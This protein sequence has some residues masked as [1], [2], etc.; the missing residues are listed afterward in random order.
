M[1]EIA[2]AVKICTR[3]DPATKLPCQNEAT[4]SHQWCKACKAKYQRE[5]EALKGGMAMVR[6]FAKGVD[7]LRVVLMTEFD[8]LGCGMF[9][10]SEVAALIEQT[11]A[12]RLEPES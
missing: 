12:P 4:E 10:G 5:Y 3:V 8:R 9:S 6:G 7:A 2:T 1:P 11:P